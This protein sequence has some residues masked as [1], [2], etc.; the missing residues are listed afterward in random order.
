MLEDS[1][2]TYKLIFFQLLGPN[3]FLYNH[4]TI[5]RRAVHPKKEIGGTEKGKI[6]LAKPNKYAPPNQNNFFRGTT[7]AQT[8]M[9]KFR[10]FRKVGTHESDFRTNQPIKTQYFDDLTNHNTGYFELSE[11][12]TGSQAIS[13]SHPSVS[14]TVHSV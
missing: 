11:F 10:R 9:I 7:C 2:D 14:P 6:P 12:L 3:N 1:A 4:K 8:K 13:S 5:S